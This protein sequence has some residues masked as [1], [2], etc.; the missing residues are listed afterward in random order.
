[1]RKLNLA[2]LVGLV[3]VIVLLSGATYAVHE[4]Q[5]QRNAVTLLDSARRA[6]AE[7]KLAKAAEFL[8]QYLNL[9]REDGKTWQ[10]YAEV[11]DRLY[12]E[13]SPRREQVFLVYEQALRLKPDDQQ[14]KRRCAEVALKIGRFQEAANYLEQLLG[15][16]ED[17]PK[18]AIS[19]LK[20]LLGQCYRSMSSFENAEKA[21]RGSIKDDESRVSSYDQLA[22]LL[23]VDLRRS[24]EA[25]LI[26]EEMVKQNSK[27]GQAYNNRWRYATEFLPSARPG[28]L[29]QARALAPD[30]PQVLLS[31]A[32]DS[33]RK[34]DLA[35]ARAYLEKGR[36]LDPKNL[37]FAL[38]LYDLEAREQHFDRAETVLREAYEAIPWSGLAF[39]LALTLIAENKIDG[40]DQANDYIAILRTPRYTETLVRYLEASKAM[41]RGDWDKA[42]PE[43]EAARVA[44]RTDE[45]YA[46]LYP[47]ANL[48][49]AECYRRLNRDE[50]ALGAQRLA[51]ERPDSA[52]SNRLDLAFTLSR[53]GQ[54][55][56]A[57]KIFQELATKQ[58]ELRIPIARI[59]IQ[60][61]LRLPREQR[62]WAPVK[63]QVAEV[64]RAALKSPG[65][66]TLLKADLLAVQDTE[67]QDGLR[68]AAKLIESAQVKSPGE[69]QLRLALARLSQ[70][71]NQG[72]RARRILDQA[73][74]DLKPSLA[75]TL[76][77]LDSWGQQG[78]QEAKEAV[79]RMAESRG[80]MPKGDRPAFLN[81][82]ALTEL[83]LGELA[84]ARQYWSEV[85]ELEPTNIMVLLALFDLALEQGDQQGAGNLVQKIKDLEG[86]EEKFGLFVEAALLLDQ[87]RRDPSRADDSAKVK[88]LAAK[89]SELHPTWWGGP[90]LS[91]ELAELDDLAGGK[92]AAITNYLSAIKLGSSQRALARRLVGLLNESNEPNHLAKIDEVI[93]LLRERGAAVEDLT[94]ESALDAFRK[95]E[96][97]RGL[98]L[99]RRVYPETSNRYSDHLA[100]GR[101]YMTA[102][103]TAEA[104]E[105]FH[106][107]LKK[108]PA[109]PATWLTYVV[110]LVQTKQ[111]D[112]AKAVV[113]TAAKTL[114]SERSDLTLAECYSL[115][116]DY[117]QAQSRIEKALAAN[118]KD[119]E[120]LRI[121]GRLY[122]EQSQSA[123]ARRYLDQWEDAVKSDEAA[124]PGDIA[125]ASRARIALLVSTG[126]RRDQEEALGLVEKSL[127]AN[128]GNLENQRIRATILAALP[129]RRRE[130]RDDLE[131]IASANQAGI[132]EL[133][134][135]ARLYLDDRQASKYRDQ[136]QKLLKREGETPNPQHLAHFIN[137]LIDSKELV[138]AEP[139]LDRLKKLEPESLACLD[140]EARLLNARNLRDELRS[141]L[142]KYGQQFPDQIGPVAELLDRYKFP[143]AAEQAYKAFV[144]RNPKQPERVLVLAAF[145]GR[146][147]RTVEAIKILSGALTTCRLEQVAATALSLYDAPSVTEDQRRQVEA[148]VDQAVKKHQAAFLS[149]KLG[150][151][152]IR[153]GRF[154]EAEVL[155]RRMLG[156]DPDH[157]EALN[158]LAW[159]LALRDQNKTQEALKLID[160][161][162]ENQGNLPTL[163]DTRA[164]VLIR[165]GK[166]DE[167]E[168]VLRA[169]VVA[170]PQS[171]SLALHLA[172]ARQAKG[173]TDQARKEYN[174]AESL[175]LVIQELDPLER[176][177]VQKL[178]NELSQG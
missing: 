123:L 58:P 129:S 91:G 173:D 13:G 18:P 124:S 68:E 155:Y 149:P 140:L 121:V 156:T 102:G 65:E 114:P 45:E 28:D 111:T 134:L 94:V 32:V 89:I 157:A 79:A 29:E 75:I 70:R 93:Q 96:F 1:M 60:K 27:S 98:A 161:A 147:G 44:L 7:N 176:A 152:W 103:R 57:L 174:R 108:G 126:R 76:A 128:P 23:R 137:F 166:L 66:L 167:A 3:A 16:P 148:W 21:Y 74:K 62:N 61:T 171:K 56:E 51:S 34:N 39:R 153:Q 64:E 139:W 105:E 20:E 168:S 106:L 163:L 25:D 112:M 150:A 30:D 119:R 101:F 47:R 175:G 8:N 86:K 138:E 5:V 2:F 92:A 104:G 151:I 46:S 178:R 67:T 52:E 15:D 9:K 78:D 133:F 4:Y 63:Q 26:I 80:Q 42:I 165:A 132:D 55:D 117:A 81:L 17:K 160:H 31:A 53:M 73:E 127:Q 120:T 41:K 135:L 77:R 159:V 122:L 6:E 36:K 99:A 59:M 109:V 144:A 54:L 107:A 69:L 154:D 146:Q 130:A 40:P 145:Y 19:E 158:N 71:L 170:F 172:W 85:A 50:E 84:L 11:I 49:L 43:L 141:L 118:P 83:R 33:E 162:I 87:V 35:A 12:P 22:R 38:S 72:A 131:K 88:E 116:G 169:A 143:E 48:M 10:W 90:A 125:A 115:I 100:L 37:A 97:D 14:L 95:K 177:I 142:D 136:M 164:V 24:Q 113:A 82:L 110:F